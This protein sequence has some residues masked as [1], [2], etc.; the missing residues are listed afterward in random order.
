MYRRDVVV[1][2]R[3]HPNFSQ[4]FNGQA[5]FTLS[6]SGKPFP[7]KTDDFLEKVTSSIVETIG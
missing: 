1:M 5:L 2:Y 7:A 3:K 6:S 4:L